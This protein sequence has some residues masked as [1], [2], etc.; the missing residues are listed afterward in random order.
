[1]GQSLWIAATLLC[2]NG[3]A[4]QSLQ[5]AVIGDSSTDAPRQL[6][7][8]AGFSQPLT[9]GTYRWVAGLDHTQVRHTRHIQPLRLRLQ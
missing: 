3:L 2:T 5:F 6:A 7:T 4:A 8:G 9:K 1:M